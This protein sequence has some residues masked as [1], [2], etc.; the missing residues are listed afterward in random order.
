MTDHVYRKFPDHIEA[1]Q[2]ILQRDTTFGEICAEYE[3]IC[4]W[5]ASQSHAEPRPEKET[6]HARQVIRS[7]EAEIKKALR[8]AGFEISDVGFVR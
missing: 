5:L 4:T 7:L 3:E 6:E 8:D 1:I 2:A